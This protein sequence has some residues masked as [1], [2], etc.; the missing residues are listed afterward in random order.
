MTNGNGKSPIGVYLNGINTAASLFPNLCLHF[1]FSLICCDYVWLC[2]SLL[3]VRGV[4][5]KSSSAGSPLDNVEKPVSD[6][7]HKTTTR[8]LENR[9]QKIL[10]GN[11][12]WTVNWTPTRIQMWENWKCLQIYRDQNIIYISSI[13][14]KSFLMSINILSLLAWKDVNIFLK[15]QSFLSNIILNA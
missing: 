11:T 7:V 6:S 12:S 9:N 2:E 3:N 10:L 8:N 1:N 15:V 4:V 14:K 5:Y 13:R